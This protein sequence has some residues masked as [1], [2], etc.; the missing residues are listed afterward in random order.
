MTKVAVVTGGAHGIGKCI[1]EEFAK[2]GVAVCVIDI[3]ENPYFVGDISKKEVLEA[4]AER[5]INAHTFP[6]ARNIPDNMKLELDYYN[7]RKD[8]PGPGGR[9]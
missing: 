8:R 3:R 6:I 9:F 2:Q 5:V 1:C 4:F 7:L